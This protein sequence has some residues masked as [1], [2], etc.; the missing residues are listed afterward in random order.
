MFDGFGNLTDEVFMQ[1]KGYRKQK[2][3]KKEQ[4]KGLRKV[5][6]APTETIAQKTYV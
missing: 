6:L 5:R 3:I 1:Y 2:M 4:V